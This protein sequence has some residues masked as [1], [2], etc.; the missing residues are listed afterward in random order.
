MLDRIMYCDIRYIYQNK[1]KLYC[2]Y[3]DINHYTDGSSYSSD[4]S[5]HANIV[6]I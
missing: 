1:G 3:V 5:C 6:Y 2:R 4:N